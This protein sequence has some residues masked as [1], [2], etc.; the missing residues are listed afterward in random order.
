MH[1]GAPYLLAL[2]FRRVES[3]GS[4]GSQ[5]IT[6][7]G[8]LNIVKNRLANMEN[9]ISAKFAYKMHRESFLLTRKAG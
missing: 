9:W 7:I 3:H 4:P 6:E 8:K 5:F 2:S 1:F